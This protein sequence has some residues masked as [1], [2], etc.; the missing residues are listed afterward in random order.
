MPIIKNVEIND[1][2]EYTISI[3]ESSNVIKAP[4]IDISKT[5]LAGVGTVKVISKDAQSTSS[6]SNKFNNNDTQDDVDLLDDDGASS[7]TFSS[8]N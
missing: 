7:D 5:V 6:K 4:V 1:N 3:P 8:T 2:W